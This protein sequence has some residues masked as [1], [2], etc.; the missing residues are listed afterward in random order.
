MIESVNKLCYE[1]LKFPKDEV[2]YIAN[3]TDI[4]YNSFIKKQKKPN[5]V[6]KERKI[7]E[8]VGKLKELH[9]RI[10]RHILKKFNFPSPPFIGGIK[11]KIIF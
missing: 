9:K 7:D 11:G 10:Y 4:C 1:V 8:A 3:N 6:I 5:G 2:L